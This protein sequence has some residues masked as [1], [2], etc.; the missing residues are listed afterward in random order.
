ML[1][2]IDTYFR[3]KIWDVGVLSKMSSERLCFLNM[4][5]EAQNQRK[6]PH[7]A[8]ALEFSKFVQAGSS[9]CFLG[10]SC[11]SCPISYT[12]LF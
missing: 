8:L 4:F 9:S 12:F 5:S 6:C 1:G 2:K 11:C 7:P 3:T 10:G